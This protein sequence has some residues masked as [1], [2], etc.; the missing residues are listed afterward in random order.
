[1]LKTATAATKGCRFCNLPLLKWWQ[2]VRGR[3]EKPIAGPRRAKGRQGVLGLRLAVGEG[4]IAVVL[5]ESRGS[6]ALGACCCEAEKISNLLDALLDNLVYP[7][8]GGPQSISGLP[9]IHVKKK[10][11]HSH[12]WLEASYWCSLVGSGDSSEPSVFGFL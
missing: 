7:R 1:M 5:L 2:G 11:G 9:A 3:L 8:L 12:F 4:G 10:L 6:G